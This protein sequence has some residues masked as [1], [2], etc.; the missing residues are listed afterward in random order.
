MGRTLLSTE[1]L[2]SQLFHPS[3]AGPSES[4]VVF[5]A[6]WLASSGGLFASQLILW[7][8]GSPVGDLSLVGGASS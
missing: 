1:L 6:S 4:K 7:V 5:V 3:I 8:V 2:A